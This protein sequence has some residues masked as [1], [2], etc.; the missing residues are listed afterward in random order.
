MAGAGRPWRYCARRDFVGRAPRS[1][2]VGHAG[3]R[4]TCDIAGPVQPVVP[5]RRAGAAHRYCDPCR[6]CQRQPTPVRPRRPNR[7]RRR[8]PCQQDRSTGKHRSAAD[9]G[10]R[11]GRGHR[12]RIDEHPR[13]R[14]GR[15]TA[16]PASRGSSRCQTGR[17]TTQTVPLPCLHRCTCCCP[18]AARIG[19]AV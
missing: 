11:R 15:G 9:H 12:D 6:R 17:S 16:R 19:T 8:R 7:K 10:P 14:V 13:R 4:G 5:A 18:D 2:R 3:C 1:A